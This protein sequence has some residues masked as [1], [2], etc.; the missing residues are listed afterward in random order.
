MAGFKAVDAV[1]ALDYD[2]NPY[3]KKSGVIPEPSTKQVGDY[4][5]TLAELAGWVREVM[6]AA[7]RKAN[8]EATEDDLATLDRV[9]EMSEDQI[10]EY[11]RRAYGAVVSVT[12]GEISLADME[13]LPFRVAAAFVQWL[14]VQFDPEASR[15]AMNR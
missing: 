2:L 8:D 3:I 13:A 5:T 14:G 10:M 12:G 7:T 6:G 1:E 15:A 4:Q 11:Q 9:N